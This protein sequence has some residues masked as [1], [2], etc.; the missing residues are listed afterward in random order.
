M[1]KV[2]PSAAAALEGVLF[3]GMTVMLGGFRL[4]GN[5]ETL[6]DAVMASGARS[7]TIVSNN[8]GSNGYGLWK[9]LNNR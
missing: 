6:I 1:N 7:L 5:P 2:Y 3:D 4:A 9:L 8:C